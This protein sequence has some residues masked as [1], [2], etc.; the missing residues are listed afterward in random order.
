MR[1]LVKAFSLPWDVATPLPFITCIP[2]HAG[3][4][5]LR[6]AMSRPHPTL[7]IDVKAQSYFA[8][9]RWNDG[10]TNSH[11]WGLPRGAPLVYVA[12]CSSA[13]GVAT[14]REAAGFPPRCAWVRGPY[15]AAHY[16]YADVVDAHKDCAVSLTVGTLYG[17]AGSHRD[18]EYVV[19]AMG[20]VS[21]L[22]A[23]VH[24]NMHIRK[25]AHW[26]VSP[27]PPAPPPH[28]VWPQTSLTGMCC[29]CRPPTPPACCRTGEATTIRPHEE[30]EAF[31]EKEEEE[32]EEEEDKE[33]LE[34]YLENFYYSRRKEKRAHQQV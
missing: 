18:V 28:G 27:V 11:P 7:A 33:E 26:R 15:R 6:Q 14:W 29:M 32:E 25:G 8:A 16:R 31:W 19:D 12:A 3:A 1:L 23:T 17:R 4:S 21:G 34:A 13:D 20:V 9:C 30:E 24:R 2:P 10:S 5:P 22:R